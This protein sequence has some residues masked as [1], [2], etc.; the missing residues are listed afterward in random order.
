M[1]GQCQRCKIHLGNRDV[2]I[3]ETS[4][5]VVVESLAPQDI[6][7]DALEVRTL[8]ANRIQLVLAVYLVFLG[9]GI[10]DF[11]VWIGHVAV[12][13]HQLVDHFLCDDGV[14]RQVFHDHVLD[15]AD[16]TATHTDINLSDILLQYCLQLFDDIG[17]AKTC[18]VDIVYH[19][20][21]DARRRVFL[22]CGKNRDA[23]IQV[24]LSCYTCHL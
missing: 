10:K 13:V 12:D 14:L 6:Q 4:V 18:L 1:V 9:D 20:F 7:E 24:L 21:P 15:A 16:R 17:Q 8:Y 23:S 22:H 5:D 2:G 3:L 19:T 11:L